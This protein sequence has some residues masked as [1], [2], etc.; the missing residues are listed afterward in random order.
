MGVKTGNLL[1]LVH[2]SSGDRIQIPSKDGTNV[3]AAVGALDV[4]WG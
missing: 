2:V 1:W 3:H 4:A